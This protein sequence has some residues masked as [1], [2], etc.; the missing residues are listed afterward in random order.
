MESRN[1]EP[2][3]RTLKGKGRLKYRWNWRAP[4]AIKLVL[5][6]T[7]I[8]HGIY[9]ENDK[10]TYPSDSTGKNFPLIWK[11]ELRYSHIEDVR[12][13]DWLHL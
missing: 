1:R 9:D 10:K 11:T 3:V 13:K 4:Q 2:E 12:F 8:L 7:K 5:R 6:S